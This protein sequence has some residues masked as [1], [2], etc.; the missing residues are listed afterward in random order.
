MA[1]QKKHS[2]KLTNKNGVTFTENEQKKLISLVNSVNRK[3]K[4]ILT[5]EKLID[6]R[7][8]LGVDE[9]FIFGV[10][11]EKNLW[12]SGADTLLTKNRSKSFQRFNSKDEYRSYMKELKR[13]AKKDY[14]ETRMK[15]YQKNQLK[16]IKSVYGKDSSSIIRGLK[17]LTP[18]EYLKVRAN[19]D[20]PS[21]SYVYSDEEYDSKLEQLKSSYELINNEFNLDERVY[22]QKVKRQQRRKGK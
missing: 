4:R 2:K 12:G 8:A 15:H 13:L 5:D 18:K 9:G 17:Q 20:L 16:A 10:H 21:I 11:S 6:V 3:R 19:F 1:R 7:T 14:V 22:Q